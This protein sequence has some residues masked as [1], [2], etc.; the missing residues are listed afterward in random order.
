MLQIR[1]GASEL[2]HQPCKLHLGLMR[3]HLSGFLTGLNCLRGLGLVGGR[4]CGPAV[5]KD[6][7]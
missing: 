1:S 2:E 6:C 4:D 3:E 5:Y 7:E